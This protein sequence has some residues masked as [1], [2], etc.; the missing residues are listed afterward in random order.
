VLRT[1]QYSGIFARANRKHMLR[2]AVKAS[3]R[4]AACSV[5]QGELHLA[6]RLAPLPRPARVL[7]FRSVIH[8]NPA[9]RLLL[10]LQGWHS[11]FAAS[12]KSDALLAH[13]QRRGW[14]YEVYDE[15]SASAFPDAPL[16]ANNLSVWLADALDV[17]VSI[18]DSTRARQLSTNDAGISSAAPKQVLLVGSSLGGWLS[19]LIARRCYDSSSPEWDVLQRNLCE[20]IA[21]CVLVAAAPDMTERIFSRNAAAQAALLLPHLEQWRND[22][23]SRTPVPSS[24]RWSLPS[25]HP[26]SG[27]RM[28]LFGLKNN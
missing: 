9:D 10:F 21:G 23:K 28:L 19:L 4:G 25:P 13:C 14:D 5:L 16:G 8:H 26:P 12:G 18:L 22:E 17:L 15:S 27:E 3:Q 24:S 7:P 11:T 2:R 1:L 20:R 6:R